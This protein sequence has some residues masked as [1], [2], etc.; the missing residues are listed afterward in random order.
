[1]TEFTQIEKNIHQIK[2]QI[3]HY[4]GQYS[5]AAQNIQLLAVSKTKSIK[6]IKQAYTAG[7]R[8]F[9]ETYLQE[10]LL[11]IE[12]LHELDIH[13]HFIGHIQSNKTR[14]LANHFQW[15]H[16][17]DRF[18]IAQRLSSHR[19]ESLPA[20]NICLQVNPANEASKSGVQL[21]QL[22]ELAEA[23]QPLPNIRLRGLMCIPEKTQILEMQRAIF[24]PVTQAFNQ[25]NARGFNLD[26][27]S[28]GMSND[29]QAAIAEGANMLRIG[30]AIFGARD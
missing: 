8:H 23:V 22:Q 17:V 21:E 5:G 4:A 10:A 3:A 25:L 7:Q 2:R 26:T 18:K 30:T 12:Q 15:V 27:L 19:D 24:K 29:M 28:M 9:A 13:W 20:L 6:S 16:T 1:M 11:K 14:D